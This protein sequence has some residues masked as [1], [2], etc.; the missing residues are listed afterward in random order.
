[1]KV[2]QVYSGNLY[3]GVET[4]L[5]TLVRTQSL[6]PNLD[7]DY[8]LCFKG[9]LSDELLSYRAKVHFLGDVKTSYFWT[10]IKAKKELTQILSNNKYDVVICNSSWSQAIFGPVVKSAKIPLVYYLH[11]PINSLHWLDIWASRV[12]PDKA[13]GVSQHTAITGGKIYPKINFDVLNYPLPWSAS[14]FDSIDRNKIRNDM[15]VD[16]S[17]TIII[18]V[19]RMEEWKGH[20]LHLKA[21]SELLDLEDWVCWFVGGVQ[22]PKEIKYLEFLKEMVIQLNLSDRVFF[23]GERKNIPELL[24]GADIFCQVNRGPEGFSLAFMEAFSAGLPIVTTD[25]GGASELID[26][27]C[28]Y[29][30]SKS[31]LASE[32]LRYLIKHPSI[33]RE[34][35]ERAKEKVSTLCSPE[36]QIDRLYGLLSMLIYQGDRI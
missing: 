24:T 22:R 8:A 25:M 33:R 23:L 35:G 11:G 34:M 4:F 6:H 29:V 7:I 14:K 10:V 17:T 15:A 13:I 26:P 32:K 16:D 18:Q 19:S 28:G 9:R 2:L 3:G 12:L 1:M 21:L 30:V 31:T 27:S 5:V 36:Q 20:D